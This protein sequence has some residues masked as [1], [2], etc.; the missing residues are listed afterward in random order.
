LGDST[1][2][3]VTIKVVLAFLLPLIV[4][5]VSLAVFGK[6]L[7]RAINTEGLQITLSFLLALVVTFVYVL[8]AKVVNKQFGLDK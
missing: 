8:I 6:V 2:E 3:S 1:G 5:I 7:A 4:F